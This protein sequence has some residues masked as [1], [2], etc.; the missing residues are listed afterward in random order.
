MSNAAYLLAQE[1]IV[2]RIL[3]EYLKRNRPFDMEAIV[4]FVSS[5]LAKES[6]DINRSGIKK[7]LISLLEKKLIARGTSLTIDDILTLPKRRELYEFIKIYPGIYLNRIIRELNFPNHI[8]T[9]HLSI[10]TK[11]SFIKE[12]FVSN[13]KVYAEPNVELEIIKR[14]YYYYKKKSQQILSYLKQN[15]Y[16]LTKTQI[17]EALNMHSSTITGYLVKLLKY[18]LVIKERMSNRTLY[19]INE[20]ILN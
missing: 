20:K 13:H 15:D 7:I 19:F 1:G 16:G 3:R 14:N 9:W 4:P 6:I 2:Y 5:R 11:F 17:A 8:A 12:E 10:L 18:K